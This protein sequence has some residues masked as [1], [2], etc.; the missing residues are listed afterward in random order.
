VKNLEK[1][2]IQ[3]NDSNSKMTTFEYKSL[4]KSYRL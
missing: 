3:E 4:Q 1:I 2:L